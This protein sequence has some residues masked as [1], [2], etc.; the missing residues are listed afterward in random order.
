M[1][2]RE[3]L[4]KRKEVRDAHRLRFPFPLQLPHPNIPEA[5]Q[6]IVILQTNSRIAVR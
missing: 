1:A 6:M 3:Y 4:A 5:H 2:L